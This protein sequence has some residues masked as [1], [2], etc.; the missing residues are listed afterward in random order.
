MRR[1]RPTREFHPLAPFF[2]R[3]AAHL[4]RLLTAEER[5]VV[6]L[7]PVLFGGRFRRPGYDKEPPGLVCMPRRRRWG[8]ACEAIDFPP[9]LGFFAARPLIRSIVLVPNRGGWQLV[10]STTS[11]LTSDDHRRLDERV[12]MVRMLLLRHAPRLELSVEEGALSPERAFFAGVVGG[13]A[14]EVSELPVDPVELLEHAPTLLSKTLALIVDTQSPFARLL[15]GIELC[16]PDFFAAA[17]SSDGRLLD[18]TRQLAEEPTLE[19]LTLA[20]R[21]VRHA[22]RA[23]FRALEP[24]TRRSLSRALGRTILSARILPAFRPSL[25]AV[26]DRARAEELRDGQE[27]RIELDGQ[28]LLSAP[29]LDALRARALSESPRLCPSNPEW[30]RARS[31]LGQA[32]RTTLF[33]VEPGFVKHL[34]L[35]ASSAGR[36]RARRLTADATIRL[37]LSLKADGRPLEI[38]AKPGADPVLVARLAQLA[39]SPVS[40]G[41]QFGV[42][43]G[44]RLL[45]STGRHV[46][47]V[48]FN[49][50]L[51]RPRRLTLLPE[52]SDWLRALRPPRAVRGMRA[53]HLLVDAAGP[54]TAR[55][56]FVDDA[57][58]LFMEE[59]DRRS[60][61]AW[62]LNTRD[63]LA[64]VGATLSV[65]LTPSIAAISGRRQAQS[66]ETLELEVELDGSG[67]ATVIFEHERFGSAESLGW[68]ALAETVFSRWPPRTRGRVDVRQLRLASQA[69]DASPLEVLSIRSR[70]LRRLAG[71]VAT[72]GRLLEAA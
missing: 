54:E 5:A 55:A 61:D 11:S 13:D 52:R 23:R 63:L 4:L 39:S 45:L 48:Q 46:R 20:S 16:S 14:L 69:P 30:L 2:R 22:S 31:L 43:R 8:K 19:E 40:S 51:S 7:M 17:A 59:L 50:A 29:S 58:M 9:P 15:P 28:T 57:G 26:L 10:L 34:V 18:L 49:R 41:G 35:T 68:R 64:S 62:A 67:H 32:G 56:L 33:I 25:E 44:D 21:V 60:F 6:R 38:S 65:S 70:V 36:L 3:R 47:D 42:Q 66:A 27:W 71:Q 24:Q 53:V 1:L 12:Q 37:A 72:L